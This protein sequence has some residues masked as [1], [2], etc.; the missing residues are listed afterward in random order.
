MSREAL[1]RITYELTEIGH[2][3][4][5]YA[6]LGLDFNEAAITRLQE[7]V[8][9]DVFGAEAAKLAKNTDKKDMI[10]AQS[11]ETLALSTEFVRPAIHT[12][13][14][15]SSRALGTWALYGVNRYDKIGGTFEPHMDSAATTVAI[16]TLCGI[17]SMDIYRRYPD[18][19]AA[20]PET[21]RDIEYTVEL[22]PGSIMLIDG[23]LDPPHAVTCL[24][25]PSLSVI[26]DVPDLLRV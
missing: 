4:T 21:F 15:D 26:V 11:A 23:Q 5:S 19:N 16:V 24:E 1:D 6:E 12:L 2:A 20:K 10:I 9:N 18:Q 7:V 14:A 17:R 13:F 25:A 8:G 22:K 3:L